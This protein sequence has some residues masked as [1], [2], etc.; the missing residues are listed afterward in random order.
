M[1]APRPTRPPPVPRAFALANEDVVA[2]TRTVPLASKAVPG[3]IADS[4]VGAI[5]EVLSPPA[6]PTSP[7]LPILASANAPPPLGL[8][9]VLMV[10]SFPLREPPFSVN[11]R[12]V[13]L[14]VAVECAPPAETMEAPKPVDSAFAETFASASKDVSF[15]PESTVA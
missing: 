2:R 15:E 3:P 1:D 10:T 13:G 14:S 11:A 6:P 9:R 4:T 5:E 8:S 12:T 7:T